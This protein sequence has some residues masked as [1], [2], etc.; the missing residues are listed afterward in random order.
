MSVRA[1]DGLPTPLT[2]PEGYTSLIAVD[3]VSFGAPERDEAIQAQLRQ[4][5]YVRLRKAFEITCLPWLA[6]YVEDRGDG[7]LI[8]LP[9]DVPAYLLLDPLAHHLKAVLRHG[10]RLYS[11]ALQ[12]RLRVAVNAG[13]VHRDAYGVVG[14]AVNHLFRFLDAPAFKEA[15]SL[16][17]AEVGLIVSDRLY[18]DVAGS[19]GYVDQAQYRPV[20]V[21]CKETK[22]D[23]HVWLSRTSVPEP[24]AAD[25]RDEREADPAR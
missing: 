20:Q 4:L 21:V 24:W 23:A 1:G 18:G 3:I 9:P 15:I 19:G 8:V 13:F 6:C 12:M 7:A 17:E 11:R 5:M 2:F 10:N 22:A 16:S 25:P 14:H